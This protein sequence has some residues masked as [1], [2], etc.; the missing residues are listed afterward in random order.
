MTSIVLAGGRSRR[1]GQ[2]KR[3]VRIGNETLINRVIGRLLLISNEI[4]IVIAQGESPPSFS[5]H[6]EVK[7]VADILPLKGALG[8]IYTG[9]TKAT[10]PKSLVV[11]SDMP[12]LNNALL[13]HMIDVSDGY[14]VIAPWTSGRPEPLHAI[15]S[16]Q[17][18]KPIEKLLGRT[19]LKII[20]FWPEVRVKPIPEEDV[21][22][23]DPQHLSFF[24][25]NTI[26]DLNRARE[27][28]RDETKTSSSSTAPESD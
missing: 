26:E 1:L 16:K 15:Y 2:D 14:D 10:S 18:L 17:C 19:E 24:N 5:P 27:L 7:V 22:R 4:F 25:V 13:Q 6:P 21:N 20:D 9:L 28:A 11:A 23:F 3:L 12:F 8:G